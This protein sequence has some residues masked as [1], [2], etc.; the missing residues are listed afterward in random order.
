MYSIIQLSVRSYMVFFKFPKTK[1]LQSLQKSSITYRLLLFIPEFEGKEWFVIYFYIRVL[2]YWNVQ[3]YLY[4]NIKFEKMSKWK[5]LYNNKLFKTSKLENKKKIN[6][7]FFVRSKSE[8]S[9]EVCS[10]TSYNLPKYH[11]SI[12]CCFYLFLIGNL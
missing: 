7:N 3:W 12:C 11:S 2:Q 10:Y 1:G 8:K 4:T 9:R 6:Y 5:N